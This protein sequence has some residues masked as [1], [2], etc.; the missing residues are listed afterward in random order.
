MVY[1]WY[2]LPIGGLY[3]TYHL[4]G[5]PETTIELRSFYLRKRHCAHDSCNW[6]LWR[7]RR[8]DLCPFQRKQIWR[9]CEA[10]TLNIFKPLADGLRCHYFLLLWEDWQFKLIVC[11][12]IG[13]FC[14]SRSARLW[15][16]QI[17]SFS[18]T[19]LP[20]AQSY[21]SFAIKLNLLDFAFFFVKNCQHQCGFQD[22]YDKHLSQVV[23]PLF[24]TWKNFNL[25]CHLPGAVEVLCVLSTFR[26]LSWTL[27]AGI[28]CAQWLAASEEPK[29][30]R[31][32][33]SNI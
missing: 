28:K 13:W 30:R 14:Y 27:P 17:S 26:C 25:K 29:L 19:C 6:R 20:G 4:L 11:S 3:A 2:I 9:N 31:L 33:S 18:W 22:M 12:K 24:T 10:L 5:E 32:W 23:S 21:Y 1:K 7:Y 15:P 8:R 16:K